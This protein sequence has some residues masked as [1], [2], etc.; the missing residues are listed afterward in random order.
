MLVVLRVLQGRALTRGG[1][2]SPKCSTLRFAD[3][4]VEQ[5]ASEI[6][7]ESMLESGPGD[8]PRPGILNDLSPNVNY[9]DHNHVCRP[10]RATN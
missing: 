3:P 5:T 7:L 10:R 2:T 8:H 6:S 9:T 1:I 4:S